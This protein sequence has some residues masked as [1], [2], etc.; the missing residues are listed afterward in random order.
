MINFGNY[1][2]ESYSFSIMQRISTVN[3]SVCFPL[4]FC[5]CTQACIVIELNC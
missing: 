4:L 2:Q 3:I 1:K 5:V